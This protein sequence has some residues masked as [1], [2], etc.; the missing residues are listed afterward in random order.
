[1]NDATLVSQ[2]NQS[3]V[4]SCEPRSVADV[5]LRRPLLAASRCKSRAHCAAV[6]SSVGVGV[7]VAPR[8]QRVPFPEY[9]NRGF[10]LCARLGGRQQVV[11]NS[12]QNNQPAGIAEGNAENG[13]RRGLKTIRDLSLPSFPSNE[14]R[15]EIL[16]AFV[17]ESRR[18]VH[19]RSI[20]IAY[21]KN[22]YV[23]IKI[24][25]NFDHPYEISLSCH[26]T[27]FISLF[28]I[29]LKFTRIILSGCLNFH[30]RFLV[31]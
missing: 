27:S 6:A 24:I 25:L 14:A 29:I 7:G 11:I 23:I 16:K 21:Q 28:C 10:A 12:V 9:Q 2:R 4:N 1:M 22:Q 18:Y 26:V 5:S 15:R 13:R 8:Y 31:L 20:K 17:R 19:M 3:P 30:V